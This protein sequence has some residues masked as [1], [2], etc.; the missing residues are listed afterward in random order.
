MR[1]LCAF[2]HDP[3][4]GIVHAA[5]AELH[6]YELQTFAG[7]DEGARAA[8]READ[9]QRMRAR[10]ADVCADDPFCNPNLSLLP[11]SD[12]RLAVPPRT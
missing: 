12:W 1:W 9:V 8:D 10:W 3:H 7:H 11:G 2:M 4:T 6:L 5:Q